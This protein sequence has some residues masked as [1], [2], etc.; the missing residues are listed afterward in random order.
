MNE[1]EQAQEVI[2]TI[3]KSYQLNDVG[4]KICSIVYL[5]PE[6]VCLNELA[7]KT[8]YSLAT[9]SNTVKFLTNFFLITRVKKPGTKKVFVAGRNSPLD[10]L[11]SK[12][13]MAM[14]NE[15]K[16]IKKT[17]PE[18][19]KKLEGKKKYEKELELIK[20][21]YKETLLLEKVMNQMR[22]IVEKIQ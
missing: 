16:P 13:K 6:P 10:M 21:Q 11:K 8:G 20:K 9:V 4:A 17:F 18:L 1:I 12:T 22:K 15:I 14:E 2:Y 7:S 3:M 5:S 19:I